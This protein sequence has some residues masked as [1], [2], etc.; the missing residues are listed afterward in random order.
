M[1]ASDKQ[2]TFRLRRCPPDADAK[3]C[4]ELLSLAFSDIQPERVHIRSLAANLNPWE[5]PRTKVA[6]LTFHTIPTSLTEQD[7]RN[8]WVLPIEG[9]DEPLILDTHFLGLTPLNDVEHETQA[10]DCIAISGLASHPFGSWQPKGEDKTFMWIREALPR[11]L[12]ASRAILYGYDTT[13]LDSNSF[14]SIVDL[15]SSFID[16]LKANGWHLVASKPLVFLAHSLGGIILKEAFSMMA[17]G[18]DQGRVILSRFLGGVFFGVPS[19]G[20]KTSHLRAMVR[21]QVNEQ[22]ISDLSTSSEYLYNL[23]NHFSG[24]VLTRHMHLCWAYE[25]KTSPTIE[26]LEDGSYSRS[27]PEEILVTKDSATRGLHHLRTP[28]TFPINENHSDMVKFRPDDR[29]LHIVLSKLREICGYDHLESGRGGQAINRTNYSSNQTLRKLN[30]SEAEASRILH[31]HLNNELRIRVISDLMKSLEIPGRDN[32]LETIDNKF[33]RTFEW[34]FDEDSILA[35]WIRTGTGMFWIHGKPASGKSTLMKFIYQSQQTWELLHRFSS[36]A[37]QIKT[38]FFFYDR[39]TLLQRSFEGLLRSVLHQLLQASESLA[40]LLAQELQ[41]GSMPSFAAENWSIEKLESCIQ[42]VLRQTQ[43]KMELFFVFDAL[44]EYDGQPEFVCNILKELIDVTASS[45]HKLKILFSSRSWDIFKQHFG[46]YPSLQ[47]QDHT[48]ND[49]REYCVGLVESKGEDISVALGTLTPV[50]IERANGVFLWVKLVLQ[51]LI[52]EAAGGKQREELSRILDA[53]PDD[54]RDYY[55]RIIQRTP[56]KFRWEAY[57]IFQILTNGRDVFE[58][59]DLVRIIACSR[60]ST[61]QE[62]CEKLTAAGGYTALSGLEGSYSKD[63][64]TQRRSV[65]RLKTLSSKVLRLMFRGN[66]MLM[67]SAAWAQRKSQII[68]MTGGLI[69]FVGSSVTAAHDRNR[70]QLAHQTVREF[71]NGHD[72]KRAM[73]GHQARTTYDNGHTFLARYN[74]AQ[75][76]LISSAPALFLHEST[77]GRSLQ[78]FIDS[79]PRHLF[80]EFEKSVAKRYPTWKGHRAVH[81]SPVNGPLG[82]AVYNNLQLYLED[83]LQRRTEAFQETKERLLSVMPNP[84]LALKCASPQDVFQNQLA[85]LRYLLDHGYTV[86]QDPQ[87]FKMTMLSLLDDIVYRN[88][89]FELEHMFLEAKAAILIYHGHPA[90]DLFDVP[91]GQSRPNTSRNRVQALHIATTTEL[92]DCLLEKGIEVNTMD[93]AGNRALD[94]ALGYWDDIGASRQKLTKSGPLNGVEMHRALQRTIHLIK[95]GGTTSSTPR[96]VWESCL[97]DVE[98]RGLDSTQIRNCFA[99][100]FPAEAVSDR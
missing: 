13:L 15:A 46:D 95:H 26:R 19:Y 57:A 33:S 53:I 98:A 3:T 64:H 42:F 67:S 37:L 12:P 45:P 17:M 68:T 18:D 83:T 16:H 71:A 55:A 66:A 11:A 48:K 25:T 99:L 23:D 38:A 34:A 30:V 96:H 14:Q 59:S 35:N 52:A 94:H 85:L 74:L 5:R 80:L 75:G 8:E 89:A 28:T 87:A 43:I 72:F 92:I 62:A 73:L 58:L 63:M 31:W 90:G 91:D 100:L 1:A 22:V 44:D 78:L 29:N 81:G 61:Y 76:D 7:D 97:A 21:G 79:L 27:G 70:A 2:R 47:L 88:L 50:V 10:C 39:G 65:Q 32:R 86:K 69:E 54:L 60:S 4:S 82:F 41:R 20:M 51:E 9:L 40:L 56:E 24:L 84:D 6:T 49:I 93:M 77:T 36:E